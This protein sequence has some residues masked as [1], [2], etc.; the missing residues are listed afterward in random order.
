MGVALSKRAR[1]KFLVAFLDYL[2]IGDEFH[3]SM[4][5]ADEMRAA[6]GGELEGLAYFVGD[7]DQSRFADHLQKKLSEPFKYRA[8]R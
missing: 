7:E 4:E 6:A 1:E 2:K 5:S 8:A 3:P